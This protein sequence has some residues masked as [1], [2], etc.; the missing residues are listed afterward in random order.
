MAIYR[1]PSSGRQ[2]LYSPSS[3][4]RLW[5]D[6]ERS[7]LGYQAD[8]RGLQRQW[9]QT[10]SSL[11]LRLYETYRGLKEKRREDE[12]IA[13]QAQAKQD[14]DRFDMYQGLPESV[15]EALQGVTVPTVEDR[16][17]RTTGL[18]YTPEFRGLIARRGTQLDEPLQAQLDRGEGTLLEIMRRGEDELLVDPSV[19][20]PRPDPQTYA[21]TMTIGSG[22]P[23]IAG[24][25]MPIQTA[26][27]QQAFKDEELAAKAAQAEAERLSARGED[28]WRLGVETKPTST[29]ENVYIEEDGKLVPRIIQ[30]TAFFDTGVG[31][32]VTKSAILTGPND[33]ALT[34]EIPVKETRTYHPDLLDNDDNVIYV[35]R[36]NPSDRIETGLPSPRIAA[37]RAG[38]EPPGPGLAPRLDEA[39]KAQL[40]EM[41]LIGAADPFKDAST[42][43]GILDDPESSLSDTQS[44]THLLSEPLQSWQDFTGWGER[45]RT[46]TIRLQNAQIALLQALTDD[47]G[48]PSERERQRV[49]ATLGNIEGGTFKSAKAFQTELS[50]LRDLLGALLRSSREHIPAGDSAYATRQQSRWSSTASAAELFVH[51]VGLPSILE[52][53]RDVSALEIANFPDDPGVGK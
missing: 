38:V 20:V 43:F 53:L 18:S 52:T 27:I 23:D 2:N 15:L 14:R 50:A 24:I 41:S 48:Q 19:A 32:H 8:R 37:A 31:K 35:N 42:V 51:A 34:H 11:P 47:A 6:L 4:D 1:P 33:E 29:T 7:T 28:I 21:P 49:L 3:R 12:F 16:A 46:A 5:S 39:S 13:A 26:E 22:H 17:P 36:E 40:L 9:G 10:L 30:T 45:P 25:E 44:I